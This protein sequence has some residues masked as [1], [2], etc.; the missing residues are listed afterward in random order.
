MHHYIF[1]IVIDGIDP[2]IIDIYNINISSTQFL[3]LYNN[4]IAHTNDGKFINKININKCIFSNHNISW[5]M[6]IDSY[7]NISIINS[8]F[9]HASIIIYNGI[10]NNNNNIQLEI[11]NTN[12]KKFNNRRALYLDTNYTNWLPNITFTNSNIFNNDNNNT[13][14]DN[15]L[16]IIYNTNYNYISKSIILFNECKFYE[17][18]DIFSIIFNY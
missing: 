15:S 2:I 9:I 8:N 18:S 10:Y 17:N 1:Q 3:Q 5:Y 4:R 16:F 12:F 7:D 14:F 6:Y 11:I 13:N